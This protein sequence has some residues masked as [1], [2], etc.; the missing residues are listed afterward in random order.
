MRWILWIIAA[1]IGTFVLLFVVVAISRY[2]RMEGSCPDA[3]IE[4]FRGKILAYIEDQ[5][6]QSN[7]IQFDGAPRYH[8]WKL[9]VWEFPLLVDG[10]K[11]I[12][13]IDCNEQLASYWRVKESPHAPH[14]LAIDRTSEHK[15]L[16]TF[17]KNSALA[18]SRDRLDGQIDMGASNDAR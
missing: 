13:M 2:E 3:S 4:V 9:G 8:A 6:V 10:T 16:G 11:Y 5:G 15:A 1:A 17:K 14:L 7:R 12:A 18:R